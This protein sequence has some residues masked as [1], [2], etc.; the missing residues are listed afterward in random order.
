M[1]TNKLMIPTIVVCAS[2]SPPLVTE[3]F[4]E[5]PVMDICL[6]ECKRQ[7]GTSIP[8]QFRPAAQYLAQLV[9]DVN[10]SALE[11]Q[12]VSETNASDSTSNHDASA[13]VQN[14]F[15]QS[16]SLHILEWARAWT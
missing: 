12:E 16:H 5:R 6:C 13:A 14:L 10:D 8:E 2:S 4:V 9:I 1:T 3:M 7:M 15:E 11:K